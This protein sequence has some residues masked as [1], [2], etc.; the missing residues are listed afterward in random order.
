MP[1]LPTLIRHV[2][3]DD[4]SAIG[5]H[6]TGHGPAILLV[7]GAASD[8]RQW[9]RVVPLLSRRFTVMAMDR[10]GRGASGSIGPGHSAEREHADIAAVATSV[11]G[12]VHMVGHS[13]GAR[14]VLH[15][16]QLI[17]N[18]AS[19]VLYEPPLPETLTPEILESLRAAEAAGDRE[20]VLATFLLD[21]AGNDEEALTFIRSRPIWPLMVDNALTLPAELRAVRGY[22]FRPAEF[23]GW[24][25][26]VLCLV[27]GS[28]E[29]QQ[30]TVV[31]EIVAALAGAQVV[32]LPGQGHGAMFSAP[33]LF[34]AEIE[35]FVDS[36]T[37]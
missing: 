28:S 35:R 19:M 22:R 12:P 25:V 2:K 4:G 23:A 13:S 30:S 17:P 29:P 37:S 20:A 6:V 1:R 16:A 5:Y 21:V 10:R 24:S 8:A 9:S 31:D 18:V 36:L 15:A 14:F 27:G 3:A 33:E 34:A 7:H 32:A 26:P 11:D